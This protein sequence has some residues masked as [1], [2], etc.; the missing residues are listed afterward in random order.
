MREDAHREKP[1][2]KSVETLSLECLSAGETIASMSL[3][4]VHTILK[5]DS[6]YAINR[7]D[8]RRFRDISEKSKTL[9]Q[10]REL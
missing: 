6:I 1:V 10:G 5:L 9:R 3:Q 2:S 4:E 8:Q 7:S